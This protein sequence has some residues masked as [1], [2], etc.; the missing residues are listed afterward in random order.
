MKRKTSPFFLLILFLIP[1]LNSG[2]K[3]WGSSDINMETGSH[4]DHLPVAVDCNKD[5]GGAAYLDDCGS[6]VGGNTG[7]MDCSVGCDCGSTDQA[8]P[9]TGQSISTIVSATTV[10]G[11]G[12]VDSIFSWKFN[13]GGGDAICGQFANGDYWIAPARGET[14]VTITAITG[15]GSISVDADPVFESMGLL[16]GSNNYGNHD[17]TENIVPNLPVTYSTTTSLVAAIQRD[18]VTEGN[19]GTSAIYGE[20]V[21]SYDVVTILDSVPAD[22]GSTVLRPNITGESKVMLSLHDFNFSRLPSENY[23]TG[24]DAAGF[25]AIRQRWSHSTEIFAM[26]YGANGNGPFLYSEGARAFRSHAL[27]HNYGSGSART[28]INDLMAIFSDDNAFPEKQA[29]LAAMLSYGLDLYHNYFNAPAGVTRRWGQ[30]AGQLGGKYIPVSFMASLLIDPTY[31]NNIKAAAANIDTTTND[32]GPQ[33]LGQVHLS[34]GR[35][36]VWGDYVGNETGPFRKAGKYWNDLWHAQCYDGAPGV[37]NIRIGNKTQRDPHGY[38]DGPAPKAGGSYMLVSLGVQRGMVAI[39]HL[40]PEVCSTINYPAI[41]DYVIALND[42]GLDTKNDPCVTPDS[43]EILEGPCNPTA[44]LN[45]TY[46]GV[47]W[48]P[49]DP[50]DADSDCIKVATPPFNQVG[51]F[52]NLHGNLLS[53]VYISQQVEAN[54]DTIIEENSCH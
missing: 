35:S 45:C 10:N 33:E 37:C 46:Y 32:E 48:G 34:A 18:E 41:S 44:N 11:V 47:T 31:A 22:A 20:C 51:R 25:E 16:D 4:V 12:S 2:C 38:I 7:L 30:A 24:T 13:S 50:N 53:P 43:R 19:C 39:M 21:D 27:I 9:C 36:P 6:C 1:L 23:L 14:T 28:F 17:A 49:V 40:M 42:N 54:W 26:S 52:K 29:A 15:S 8:N 3:S 5:A